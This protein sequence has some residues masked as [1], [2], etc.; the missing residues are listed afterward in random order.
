M[1]AEVAGQHHGS[2]YFDKFRWLKLPDSGNL[3][4]SP[5]A[6]NPQ[7]NPRNENDH[8]QKQTEDVKRGS[9]IQ[10]LPVVVEGDEEHGH[11]ANSE[12]DEL[13]HPKVFSG[14]GIANLHSAKTHDADRQQRQQP[15]EIT[16]T[17]FLNYCDHGKISGQWTVGSGQ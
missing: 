5:L 14:L 3:D 1:P 7:A 6:V 2:R 10:Q 17:S 16:Q 11:H 15:V 4:P 13:L 9:D 8:E 12:T